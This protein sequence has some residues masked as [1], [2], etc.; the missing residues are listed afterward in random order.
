M[1]ILND[2]NE[3]RNITIRE[4]RWLLDRLSTEQPKAHKEVLQKTFYLLIQCVEQKLVPLFIVLL[5][6]QK[7]MDLT[8]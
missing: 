5:R 2:E 4:L 7:K 6:Q 1:R 8:L 3:V